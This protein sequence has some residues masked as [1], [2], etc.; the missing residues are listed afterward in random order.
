VNL[1]GQPNWKDRPLSGP[2]PTPPHDASGHT[3]HHL[4]ALLFDIIKNGGQQSSPETYINAM[5]AFG[6]ELSDREIWAV[7]SYLESTWLPHILAAQ[8]E[9]NR[10]SP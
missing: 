8:Q 5:P 1:E 7:S 3:W 10:Q 6:G 2:S 4:D 9:A